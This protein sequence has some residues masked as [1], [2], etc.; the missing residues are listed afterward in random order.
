MST[1]LP[2]KDKLFFAFQLK[3]GPLPSVHI[4]SRQNPCVFIKMCKFFCSARSQPGVDVTWGCYLCYRAKLKGRLPLQTS[5]RQA[6][7]WLK[8]RHRSDLPVC[9]TACYSTVQYM[10]YNTAIH[11]CR[12]SLSSPHSFP[13]SSLFHSATSAVLL[14]GCLQPEWIVCL[15]NNPQS[16]LLPIAPLSWRRTSLNKR[17]SYPSCL[18]FLS[19]CFIHASFHPFNGLDSSVSVIANLTFPLI[20]DLINFSSG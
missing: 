19:S 15:T 1:D 6:L 11:A 17:P 18:R 3:K 9:Q 2:L 5:S 4:K 12:S 16:L 7:Y 10:M 20:E 14:C 13:P 8:Q